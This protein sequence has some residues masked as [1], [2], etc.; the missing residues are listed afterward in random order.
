MADAP[1]LPPM[2]PIKLALILDNTVVDV[3]HVD[4]RLAAIFLSDPI[5]KDVTTT[6]G[7][8]IADVYWKYDPETNSYIRPEVE[9]LNSHPDIDLLITNK[10]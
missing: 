2:P 1:Q 10:D 6:D 4:E 7:V 5:I 3:L 9:D 8:L